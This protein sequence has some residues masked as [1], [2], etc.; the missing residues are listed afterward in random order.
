MNLE[1]KQ[2]LL[3]LVDYDRRYN[4][5]KEKFDDPEYLAWISM[6]DEEQWPQD[7]EFA[8]A[9]QDADFRE[10]RAAYKKVAEAIVVFQW[11]L[12]PEQVR[13]DYQKRFVREY[14]GVPF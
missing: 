13:V 12:L 6:L 4:K 9:R 1:L 2:L 3:L 14:G 11:G 8:Q 10:F 7:G 5:V